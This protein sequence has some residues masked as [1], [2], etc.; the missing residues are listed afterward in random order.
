MKRRPHQTSVARAAVEARTMAVVKM[1]RRATVEGVEVRGKG[2]R[3]AVT[4]R[5]R[6]AS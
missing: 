4:T 1:T 3:Q 6:E 5:A 2:R